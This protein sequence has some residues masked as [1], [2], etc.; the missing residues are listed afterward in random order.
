M[1]DDKRP[2]TTNT[3]LISLDPAVAQSWDD[4]T[5]SCRG[6]AGARIA[7]ARFMR[8]G[9]ANINGQ[10]GPRAS[11]IYI[12]AIAHAMRIAP[13]DDPT[14]SVGD[15]IKRSIRLLRSRIKAIRTR[16]LASGN[17]SCA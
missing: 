10:H 2:G 6:R 14:T 5:G 11:T 8:F 7:I 3:A 12:G 16:P 13:Q 1:L 9:H 15:W 4:V 17:P